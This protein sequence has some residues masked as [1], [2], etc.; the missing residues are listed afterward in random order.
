MDV[1]TVDFSFLI[2]Y[3]YRLAFWK[4]SSRRRD[5]CSILPCFS[6][7]QPKNVA[8]SSD[9]TILSRSGRRQKAVWQHFLSVWRC[10]DNFLTNSSQDSY[11][12]LAL[13]FSFNI[14]WTRGE[15]LSTHAHSSRVTYKD[16][17]EKKIC[18]ISTHIL[19]SQ[20]KNFLNFSPWFYRG[21]S[22]EAN[23]YGG[24]IKSSF[25]EKKTH[26]LCK[27]IVKCVKLKGKWKLWC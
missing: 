16:I 13:G 2:A 26:S 15:T 25:R 20:C 10:F 8:S 14:L 3:K 12:F 9:K 7:T 4:L 21:Y 24:H 5:S 6:V 11:S 23:E 22:S 19:Y 18:G 27:H 1:K 17:S